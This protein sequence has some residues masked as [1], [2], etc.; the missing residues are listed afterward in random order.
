MNSIQS[1]VHACLLIIILLAFPADGEVVGYW[2]FESN[3]FLSD[4]GPNL[5]SLRVSGSAPVQ[6]DA[7]VAGFSNPVPATGAAN[8]KAADFGTVQ[9]GHFA[10]DDR[11]VF[12]L[13]DL[14]IEAFAR[15]KTETSATQ[16]IASQWRHTNASARSW[17][18]GVAGASPPQSLT[19]GE[20]FVILSADGTNITT[21]GSGIVI[22]R[23]IPMHLAASIDTTNSPP[24]VSF[25]ATNLTTGTT[26]G[27]VAALSISILFDA[28]DEF[29]IG[30]YNLGTNRWTGVLDEIRLHNTANAA[31]LTGQQWLPIVTISPSGGSFSSPPVTVSLTRSPAVGEIR[32]TL[33]NS[34][35][36]VDSTLYTGPFDLAVSA[37]VK[38][39]VFVGA[40]AGLISSRTFSI[41]TPYPVIGRIVPRHAREITSSNFS[42]GAETMDR[43][44]TVYAHWRDYLGPLGAKKARI[45]SGWAKTETVQGTYNFDWLDEIVF[46]MVDQGVEPWI[47][48]CYGNP[49]YPGGG[50]NSLGGGL[51][52][53]TEALA[54]WDAYVAA[55]VERY[56][57]V[58]DEWEIWNEPD[59]GG[60]NSAEDYAKFF[61]RTAAVI[62]GVQP[63][64]TTICGA[65]TNG[66]IGTYN[67]NVLTAIQA[68]NKLHLIDQISYH[69][70]VNNPDS[71]Y[72]G[73]AAFRARVAGFDP[74]I[75]IRQGENG[76]PS[77]NQSKF[78]LSGYGWTELT[79]AKWLLRRQLGDL[80]RDIE[81]SHFS[82]MDMDY[83]GQDNSKGL[84][85]LPPSP[86]EDRPN[87]QKTVAY[88]KEG[89]YALQNMLAIFDHRLSRIASFPSNANPSIGPSVFAYEQ[90][91]GGGQVITIWKDDSTPSD[92][93]AFTPVDFTFPNGRF[94]DPV[95]VDLRTGQ[96]MEIPDARWSQSA[97]GA[98]FLSVPI[99]DTVILLAE[100]S[101]VLPPKAAWK[102]TWF[103]ST[104]LMA[105]AI[106]GDASDPE[107]D[108]RD[109]EFE[110]V[111]HTNPRQADE[112]V[113]ESHRSQTGEFLTTFRRGKGAADKVAVSVSTNLTNWQPAPAS[114]TV[115]SVPM[116]GG[117]WDRV[118]LSNL[119]PSVPPNPPS[120]HLFV[121]LSVKR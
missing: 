62:R 100:R 99:Y 50:D 54:A 63:S 109:N 82:I 30:A 102:N 58:V 1:N 117:E 61:M 89:Y 83:T 29:A 22:P 95:W 66:A 51:P 75:Q 3:S 59:N 32:Y 56:K 85:A 44:F 92:S 71:S 13:D 98:T 116:D 120:L 115:Q 68:Q 16:Y 38:A 108:G 23:D 72:G 76:A 46:D 65:Y 37:T 90:G 12:S 47:T 35:P 86:T 57:S 112:P 97:G 53:S 113:I 24:S 6:A 88:V 114:M 34:D 78:A 104:E 2:R 105:Y 45:Q 9:S 49:A 8:T 20:L 60:K 41:I 21:V 15:L 55:L 87:D 91:A 7:P 64:S 69:P 42:I 106:S 52:I 94:T 79:Q 107:G 33:D 118:T 74:R 101:V 25:S 81:T 93:N 111:F 14:T 10:A 110:W 70:Y 48:I 18:F 119:D 73:V 27:S 43:D 39:R 80:G 11:A 84:L 26:Q 96:I 19:K 28:P 36:V 77:K 31:L 103:S 4:S 67:T 40:E 17:G 121:R 5:I